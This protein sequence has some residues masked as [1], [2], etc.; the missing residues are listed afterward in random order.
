[1]CESGSETAGSNRLLL[2]DPSLP[3]VLTWTMCV[4]QGEESSVGKPDARRSYPANFFPTRSYYP[5]TEE[6]HTNPM[7]QRGECLRALAGASG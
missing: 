6:A 3:R 7:C 4:S 2:I 5:G 1:M